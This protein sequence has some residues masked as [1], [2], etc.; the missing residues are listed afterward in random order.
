MSSTNETRKFLFE[1][2]DI[3]GELVQLG[4]AYSEITAIHQYPPAVGELLGEFLCAAVMLSTTIKFEGRL[5][6]QA[7]S[8]GEIPLLMAECTSDLDIRAIAR[9]AEQAVSREFCNL[10]HGGQ[11]AITIEPLN[12]QRY[13][14]IVALDGNSLAQCVETYFT[15]SEQ[16]PTRLWL[17]A[18]GIGAAGLLLQQLPTQL[19][20]AADERAALWHEA[21]TL[22]DTVSAVETLQLAPEVLLRRLFN[23]HPV[24]LFSPENVRFACSCSR[25]RCLQAL[26]SLGPQEL[27]EIFADE[28]HV[29]MDCEFCNQQYQFTEQDL[30]S[31]DPLPET[32][33]VH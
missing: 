31:N 21:C 27:A 30:E 12:G 23:E 17:S 33:S 13:Q 25:E 10:L 1:Q 3:R 4:T 11:L 26:Y 9:G 29:N 22:A 2:A 20:S 28:G 14:G 5:I 7:R 8:E 6:L 15:N 16:L 18:D 19:I 32:H 24:R